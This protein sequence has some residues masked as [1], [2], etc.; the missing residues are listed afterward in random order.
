MLEQQTPKSGFAPTWVPLGADVGGRAPRPASA[1]VAPTRAPLLAGRYALGRRLGGG[2]WGDVHL[3]VDRSVLGRPVAIKRPPPFAWGDAVCTARF[4]REA[5]M[6]AK[7]QHPNIVTVYDYALDDGVPFLVMEYVRGGTLAE[8]ARARLRHDEIR[9]IGRKLCDALDALHAAGV[10]HRDV[11]PGN[12]MLSRTRTDVVVKLV[13]FGLAKSFRA[14]PG[15]DPVCG[16]PQYMAPE[17]IMGGAADGRADVF[18][19]GCVL[20]EL[21][22][23]TPPA[24]R[25]SRQSVL[26]KQLYATP[27][28]VSSWGLD[29]PR[30]F[31]RAVADA[32]AK[33][34]ERRASS[35]AP[36][37]AA[38]EAWG[39]SGP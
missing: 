14:H 30:A 16:T 2:A 25:A 35:V 28:P 36:L 4:E 22:T 38:I 32:L 3:A 29:V 15:P 17:Q 1:P 18:A 10:V 7:V 24:G 19:L 8:R 37:R 34:P 11:K 6:A 31:D 39:R 13:D 20:Y 33:E 12:I 9:A 27:P 23:G 5:R 26:T 21:C